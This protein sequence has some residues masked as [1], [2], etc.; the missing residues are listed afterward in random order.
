MID[1]VLR[2][3]FNLDPGPLYES[4]DNYFTDDTDYFQQELVEA[5][6]GPAN[7]EGVFKRLCDLIRKA[8]QWCVEKL[9]KFWDWIKKLIH[10]NQKSADQ[11]FQSATGKKPDENV[12][13]AQPSAPQSQK[14][15]VQPSNNNQAESKTFHFE[16]E[17]MDEAQK[18][19]K[20]VDI[21]LMAKSIQLSIEGDKIIFYTNTARPMWTNQNVEASGIN[22]D[23]INVPNQSDTKSGWNATINTFYMM[24]HPDKYKLFTDVIDMVANKEYLTKP[25]EFQNSVNALDVFWGQPNR[26]KNAI[27]MTIAQLDKFMEATDKLNTSL[28]MM[29]KADDPNGKITGNPDTMDALNVVSRIAFQMQFA[30][31]FIT[32]GMNQIHVIDAK[33]A[34]T[35]DDKETLAKFANECIKGRIPSKYIAYN[36]WTAATPRLRGDADRQKPRMGQSRLVILPENENTVLKIALNQYGIRSNNTEANISDLLKTDNAQLVAFVSQ[37]YAD[38]T[39]IDMEKCDMSKECDDSVINQ[40]SDGLDKHIHD[41]GGDAKVIDLHQANI[42]ILNG[43]WVA[44]DYGFIK[45]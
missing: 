24:S 15:S 41:H 3:Q 45:R 6:Q 18:S 17:P 12:S 9:K 20:P 23:Q 19:E 4:L 32:G 40:I 16:P 33:Y 31:N 27:G 11:C 10:R 44:T 5:T 22:P 36:L 1:S 39:A 26:V 13:S 35:I 43:Y 34:E 30:I 42:G 38:G 28:K 37:S 29:D 2:S 14:Q 8:V 7:K 25:T 21:K